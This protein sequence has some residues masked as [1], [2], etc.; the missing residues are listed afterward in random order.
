VQPNLDAGPR[1]GTHG[2]PLRLVSGADSPDHTCVFWSDRTGSAVTLDE[3]REI[4]TNIARF[5]DLP[6]QW[7]QASADS[8][9]VRQ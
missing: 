8:E 7:D 3:A 2:Q 9:G 6:A 5:F 4:S 1:G